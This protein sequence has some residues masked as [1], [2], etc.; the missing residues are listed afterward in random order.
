MPKTPGAKKTVQKSNKSPQ[1]PIT[2]KKAGT[3]QV[4]AKKLISPKK[5]TS[6]QLK[7]GLEAGFTRPDKTDF[8]DLYTAHRATMSANGCD[9]D[10]MI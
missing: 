5:K 10:D 8:T 9:V 1:K 3:G 7:K 4:S 6:N 2:K